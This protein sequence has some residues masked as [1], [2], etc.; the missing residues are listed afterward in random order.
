MRGTRAGR[1]ALAIAALLLLSRGPHP[2]CAVETVDPCTGEH[3]GEATAVAYH[4]FTLELFMALFLWQDCGSH[5]VC[6]P[7]LGS[8]R[9]CSCS[10]P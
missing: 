4:Q 10:L 7:W 2:C 6:E 5:S 1:A 9:C 3:E 8:Y